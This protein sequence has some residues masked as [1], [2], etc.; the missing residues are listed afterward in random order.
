MS[1]NEGEVLS[2]ALEVRQCFSHKVE[3]C[4]LI[5]CGSHI[6]LIM[7]ESIVLVCFN[8]MNTG[9]PRLD[10]HLENQTASNILGILNK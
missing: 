2:H 9:S 4:H 8:H 7:M 10:E 3:C 5:V 6:A 1:E